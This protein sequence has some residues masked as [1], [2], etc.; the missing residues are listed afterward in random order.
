M[1][2][3]GLA[4]VC[5][6]L[7]AGPA[8]AQ[9]YSLRA[10]ADRVGLLLG[11][12]VQS[13][14]LDDAPFAALT[15]RHVNTLV[16]EN[17]AKWDTIH[18]EPHRYDFTKADRVAEFAQAN[19]MKMRGH[20]LIWH[21]QNPPW[22][23]SMNPS[24][25]EAMA[26][27][28]DHI[29]TVVGHFRERFP[30]LIVEW[31][32]VNE[33][34]DNDGTRRQSV[35]QRWI[36]DDYLD[37]A[38]RWAREA[39]GPDVQLFYNDFFDAGMVALAEGL[40]ESFDD[41]DDPGPQFAPGATGPLPCDAVVKCA[42]VKKLVTGMKERGVPIDGVGFQGH[43]ASPAPSD[44][45]GLTAWVGELGLRWAITE[46]DVPDPSDG[47]PA[48][49]KHQA[50]AYTTAVGACLRRPGVPH[51]RDLGPGRPLHVVVDHQQRADHAGAALRQGPER[52]AG[53]GR[54]PRAAGGGEA[55]GRPGRACRRD[56]PCAAITARPA[57]DRAR[58]P[59]LH[60]RG[61]AEAGGAAPAPAGAP[62]VELVREGRRRGE[63]G[64]R[65]RRAGGARP[66]HGP[67]AWQPCAPAGC[68]PRDMATRTAAD[69]EG[70]R[71]PGVIPRLGEPLP[72]PSGAP[73][74][75][76]PQGRP[77]LGERAS[78]A[79]AAGSGPSAP[80]SRIGR[81]ERAVLADL[82]ER[83]RPRRDHPEAGGRRTAWTSRCTGR[84]RTTGSPAKE[85]GGLAHRGQAALGTR[86]PASAISNQTMVA[87]VRVTPQ[88][89][90]RLST[91]W[92]PQPPSRSEVGKAGAEA[93]PAVQHLDAQALGAPGQ[94]EL[95]LVALLD[96]A[97]DHAVGHELADEHQHVLAQPLA[98][99][100]GVAHA[101]S[102][103]PPP[104]RRVP[105]QA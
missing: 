86:S 77:P 18:P 44:Y 47:S 33:G 20:T 78:T 80:A 31:D 82:P 97:V 46:L 83:S 100:P 52:A 6:A 104:V 88:R 2:A 60:P 103:A 54:A 63:R 66:D 24:R 21:V 68:A 1:R 17:E 98:R 41:G 81:R 102:R 96:A 42:E 90:A 67:A 79:A 5:A 29:L 85:V 16:F 4:I 32:V 3:L 36:G 49:T 69:R 94:R 13:V 48:G 72:A 35:W 27:L 65:R 64:V 56:L 10:D 25:E 34:I 73:A 30:G 74:G 8:A 45:R 15:K 37:L 59:G 55:P 95:D 53:R 9:D 62:G 7:C 93:G 70:S 23:T 105:R 28:R 40:G 61:D 75:A 89:S 43:I 19:G 91:S 39:A 92:R 14:H 99:P 57:R 11:G 76:I 22:L 84:D 38:F 71:G 12:A 87:S 26:I 58:A 101:G 51:G 50:D